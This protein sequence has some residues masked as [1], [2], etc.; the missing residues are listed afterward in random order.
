MIA[1]NPNGGFN[2]YWPMPFQRGPDY[3]G[4]PRRC[5]RTAVLLGD[6]R[7]RS[8]RRRARLPPCPVPP[9]EPASAGNTHVL[10]D[11]VAGHGHY[12][13]TYLAWGVNAPGWWGEGEFKVYLDDDDY[14]TICG[15]GTEDYFG[16]AGISTFPAGATPNTPR[17]TQRMPTGDPAGRPLPEPAALRSVPLACPR[18]H[19]FRQRPAV[20]IQALGWQSGRRYRPLHD[21]IAS[22]ALFYLDRPSTR[23]RASRRR[24]AADQVDRWG[25]CTP[26]I[27]GY[28]AAGVLEILPIRLHQWRARLCCR[29]RILGLILFGM[30]VGAGA[31]LILG[32]SAKGVDWTLA[33]VAGLVG[34]FVG[35]LVISLLSG[36]G[37]QFR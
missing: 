3:R 4:E 14:P 24:R 34:S 22:A 25:N 18:P 19:P 13:G 37:L 30:L 32:K 16:G 11:G 1:V 6:L 35:G 33:L 2:S 10:L 27:R 12:V 7:D 17:R 20:E 31:Q 15:T 9:R 23:R 26:A 5:R 8:R 36:D 28:L 21:D 29:C